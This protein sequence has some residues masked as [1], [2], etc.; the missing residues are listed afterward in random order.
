MRAFIW[1][2]FG[3][4]PDRSEPR[5]YR[6]LLDAL[7]R[8]AW[9]LLGGEPLNPPRTLDQVPSL[10]DEPERA[11][12]AAHPGVQVRI[13]PTVGHNVPG[14]AITFVRTCVRDLLNRLLGTPIPAGLAEAN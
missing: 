10:V 1:S 13:V 4:G 2:V 3:V 8:P 5:D 9:V 6:P 11:A 12:F 7:D 14:R